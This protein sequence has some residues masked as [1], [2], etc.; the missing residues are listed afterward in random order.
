VCCSKEAAAAPAGKQSPAS[1]ASA[2]KATASPP[3]DAAGAKPLAQ[4]RD[5][6]TLGAH[7]PCLK[8]VGSVQHRMLSW[9][10]AHALLSCLQYMKIKYYIGVP[11]T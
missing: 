8:V 3:P 11:L 6:F 5:V 10:C 7:M 9:F 4:K 2:S 1:S